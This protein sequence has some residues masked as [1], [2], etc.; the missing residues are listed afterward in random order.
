VNAQV[1]IT[2]EAVRAALQDAADAAHVG[3]F[4]R[5]ETVAIIREIFGEDAVL[6]PKVRRERL[7]GKLVEFRDA[8]LRIHAKGPS[9]ELAAAVATEHAARAELERAEMARTVAIQKLVLATQRRNGL[10]F[11]S[12]SS[13]EDDLLLERTADPLIDQFVA[14]ID[15]EWQTARLARIPPML[16]PAAF[17]PDKKAIE[18]D[19]RARIRGN[20]W[21]RPL[22]G[23]TV[24]VEPTNPTRLTQAD[25]EEHRQLSAYMD[26]LRAAASQ[27]EAL[28]RTAIAGEELFVELERLEKAIPHRLPEGDRN[29]SIV[30]TL[31]EA[32]AKERRGRT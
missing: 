4:R 2:R 27:A 14:R 26:G 11:V 16:F 12:R 31:R 6:E 20:D 21:G 19:I 13:D 1:K 7:R 10:Q 9:E 29:K 22:L 17:V 5:E 24:I 30:A 32:A 8:A 28:K 25:S 23:A 18:A 15:Q 3:G